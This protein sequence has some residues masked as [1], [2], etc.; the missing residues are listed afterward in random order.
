M[1]NLWHKLRNFLSRYNLCQKQFFKVKNLKTIVI[2]LSLKDFCV[3]IVLKV[4]VVSF[5]YLSILKFV[6]ILNGTQ[7]VY[8]IT[9]LLQHRR[10]IDI[11]K[12]DRLAT[13]LLFIFYLQLSTP[14]ANI[15]QLVW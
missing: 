9:L 4:N 3:Q 14:E 10:S 8:Y 12:R 5:I 11:R 6:V 7:L 2:G 15:A 1:T 13:L